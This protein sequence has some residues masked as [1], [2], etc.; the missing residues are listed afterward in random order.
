MKAMLERVVVYRVDIVQTIAKMDIYKSLDGS[1]VGIIVA[2]AAAAV[3]VVVV[4]VVVV[5]IDDSDW[6]R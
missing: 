5:V 1:F 6:Y 4:V 2:A 3:I